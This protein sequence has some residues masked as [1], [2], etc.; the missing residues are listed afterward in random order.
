MQCSGLSPLDGIQSAFHVQPSPPGS[1]PSLEVSRAARVR[2]GWWRGAGP[3]HLGA[4]G[5]GDGVPGALAQRW[6][7][8]ANR[9]AK[10]ARLLQ[11]WRPETADRGQCSVGPCLE[12]KACEQA[13]HRPG[14]RQQL[15]EPC[16]LWDAVVRPKESDLRG[17]QCL[18]GAHQCLGTIPSLLSPLSTPLPEFI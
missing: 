6:R 13:G 15:W 9:G 5:R 10:R 4:G 16:P 7:C 2:Q 1:A 17:W 3:V 18:T 11:G 12:Q 14:S 8:S